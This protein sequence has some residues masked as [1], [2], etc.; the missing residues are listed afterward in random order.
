MYTLRQSYIAN[1]L[2]DKLHSLVSLASP[3]SGRREESERQTGP[4]PDADGED[5]NITI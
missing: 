5:A 3:I 1:V 4:I 2:E